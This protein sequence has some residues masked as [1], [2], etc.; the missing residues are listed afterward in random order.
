MRSLG[1]I[2]AGIG[3]A[4]LLGCESPNGPEVGDRNTRV[5]TET[6]KISH[7]FDIPDT[8]YNERK[9]QEIEAVRESYP[10][11][12]IKPDTMSHNDR[13]YLLG[14]N[15]R[16]E[17]ERKV[18]EVVEWNRGGFRGKLRQQVIQTNREDLAG[19]YQQLQSD[20]DRVTED[21]DYLRFGESHIGHVYGWK[22]D[23]PNVP[24]SPDLLKRLDEVNNAPIN[25][26]IGFNQVYIRKRDRTIATIESGV[27]IIDGIE[28]YPKVEENAGRSG[29]E[30]EAIWVVT[31]ND[32]IR[33]MWK[34]EIIFT[35]TD[36]VIYEG[37]FERVGN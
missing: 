9:S 1:L 31:G 37:P 18:E 19:F 35:G 17:V 29:M 11:M 7:R 4:G 21:G 2:V 10:T 12:N 30:Y 26:D 24:E 36:S 15:V 22:I 5:Y 28:I 34:P 25:W 8:E 33:N 16:G 23:L 14:F 32:E 27:R 3:L 20:L 13:V 6:V